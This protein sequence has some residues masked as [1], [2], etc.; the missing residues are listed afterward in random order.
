MVYG[1]WFRV[2]VEASGLKKARFFFLVLT[3]QKK[4][5]FPKQPMFFTENP[6]DIQGVPGKIRRSP[7][8][9]AA[10]AVAPRKPFG[11]S[12]RLGP[13]VQPHQGKR[14]DGSKTLQSADVSP[15]F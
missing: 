5:D 3:W 12:Q 6:G 14:I 10:C 11:L 9:S 15:V 8:L 4:C 1:L 7:L 2:M 13:Y